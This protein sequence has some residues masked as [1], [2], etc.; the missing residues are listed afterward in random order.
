MD[1]EAAASQAAY[2]ETQEM[3]RETTQAHRSLA[4]TFRIVVGA[5]TPHTERQTRHVRAGRVCVS[6]VT[7]RLLS[8]SACSLCT[9]SRLWGTPLA[10]GVGGGGA[11]G[12]RAR[13]G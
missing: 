12:D 13:G 4:P 7:C 2:Q 3:K 8:F 9:L 11:V 6:L 1:A 10:G 5:R